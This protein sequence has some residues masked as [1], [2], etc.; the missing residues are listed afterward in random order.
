[1]NN[2]SD[3]DDE[4]SLPPSMR[5]ENRKRC[6]NINEDSEEEAKTNK[7]LPILKQTLNIKN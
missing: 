5:D 4:K 2:F 3:F 6:D 7:D 1:M